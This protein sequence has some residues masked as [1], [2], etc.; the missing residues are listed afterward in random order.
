MRF[1]RKHKHSFMKFVLALVAVTT[2]A[3]TVAM[4]WV[5]LTTG[6]EMA[7]LTERFYTVIVCELGGLIVKRIFDNFGKKD[8]NDD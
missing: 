2:I 8:D 5:F 3:F 6:Q 1:K 7:T 4:I